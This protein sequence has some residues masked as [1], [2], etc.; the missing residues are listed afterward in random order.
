[1]HTVGIRV[2]QWPC[3]SYGLFLDRQWAIVRCSTAERLTASSSCHNQILSI[4]ACPRLALIRTGMNV[5]EGI[6]L[7]HIPGIPILSISIQSTD[8][9]INGHNHPAVTTSDE[10]NISEGNS[11]V[12]NN[13]FP[14]E[15]FLCGKDNAMPVVPITDAIDGR[16]ISSLLS[17]FLEQPVTLVRLLNTNISKYEY[18]KYSS[19]AN[20]AKISME[21][22]AQV[23]LV[24]LDSWRSLHQVLPSSLSILLHIYIYILLLS[25]YV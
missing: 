22:S 8:T 5:Q 3:T 6:L 12:Q 9:N 21:K 18:S 2:N 10:Y 15:V 14:K 24:S 7:I 16:N 25:R 17:E 19:F 4:R 20:S 11:S 13:A 23:S 1:M